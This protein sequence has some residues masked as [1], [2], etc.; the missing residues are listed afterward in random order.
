[1]TTNSALARYW[2]TALRLLLVL[3]VCATAWYW[4]RAKKVSEVPRRIVSLSIATDE[5]LL[6]LVA[7]ERIL[8]ISEAAAYPGM[9]YAAAKAQGLPVLIETTNAGKIGALKP[10]LVVM[11]EPAGGAVEVEL[12]RSGVQV[13][14]VDP[15]KNVA[16]V[17]KALTAVAVSVGEGKKGEALIAEMD[18]RLRE[19][20]LPSDFKT[21]P[22]AFEGSQRPDVMIFFGIRPRIFNCVS[23]HLPD[24]FEELRTLHMDAGLLPKPQRII[25]LS[26]GIAEM[27]V[28]LVPPERI[29]AVH[30]ICTTSYSNIRE[31]VTGLK[32]LK[33][34]TERIVALN[35]DLVLAA[36]YSPR[37]FLD[38]L[39]RAHVPAI[40]FTD[41][42][43][44]EPIYANLERLGWLVGERAK[45]EE[46]IR[47]MHEEIADI[48]ATI[49][50]GAPA[51]RVVSLAS[52]GVVAGSETTFN[53]LAQLAG[54]RNLAA[55][56]G[57]KGFV[58]VSIE[59]L[60]AWKP[61]AIVVSSDSEGQK[62]GMKQRLGED[63]RYRPLGQPRIVEL[64][65]RQ[66]SCV[67]Q[68]IVEAL[69]SLVRQ[70][71][72]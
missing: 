62:L 71:H 58:P 70:L 59:Q 56:Q 43:G 9:C 13:L 50:K 65:S 63:P 6:D 2:G 49:P 3:A 14:R 5:M 66:Y 69:R 11:M 31:R 8:G 51:P 4:P 38:Q 46:L 61:D 19:L 24:T 30:E 20:K 7:P 53:E 36:S 45:A 67:S 35:P 39:D 55:E 25:A 60:L 54:A 28:E 10:D 52:D 40:T 44:I 1:M 17:R 33:S 37:E 48:R 18:R 16:D 68:H 64:E 72:P 42:S 32:I 47:Q 34:D 12:R 22:E 15:P 21:W 29:A 26:L 23:H 27:L 41:F 57:F